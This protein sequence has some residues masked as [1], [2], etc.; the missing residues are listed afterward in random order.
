MFKGFKT[1]AFG[2]ALAFLG[3]AESIGFTDFIT[4]HAGAYTG[5]VGIAVMILRAWTSTPVF[6][7]TK[8]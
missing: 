2:A 8:R 7:S 1:I 4:E 5:I 3:G 6:K